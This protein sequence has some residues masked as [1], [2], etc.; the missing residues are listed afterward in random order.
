MIKDCR[1]ILGIMNLKEKEFGK[2]F[3]TLKM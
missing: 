1:K 2:G 3:I